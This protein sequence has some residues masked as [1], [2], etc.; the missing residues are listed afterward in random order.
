MSHFI[1]HLKAFNR[2]ERFI[3]L[4]RTL[5]QDTF[6]LD[7]SFRK[8]VE[9][10]IDCSVPDDAFVAMDYHLNWLHIA[11]K[12]RN[13]SL[14]SSVPNDLFP[15]DQK[16]QLNQQDIDLLVAFQDG[17]DERIILVEAKADTSWDNSQLCAKAIRLDYIFRDSDKGIRPHFLLMSPSRSRKV[18]TECWPD[19]MMPDKP[20]HIELPLGDELIKIE[21]LVDGQRILWERER[22]DGRRVWKKRG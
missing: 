13:T 17:S 16:A 20:L 7:S 22:G 4:K 18:E 1:S 19:W 21:G 8:E 2:K 11:S 3:L 15:P 6:S 10:L 12:Y 9:C 5:G 14:P